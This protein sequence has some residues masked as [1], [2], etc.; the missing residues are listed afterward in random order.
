MCGKRGT[1]ILCAS[2]RDQLSKPKSRLDSEAWPIANADNETKQSSE[3]VP[4]AELDV[5]VTHDA[6]DEK[7]HNPDFPLREN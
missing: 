2:C 7:R 6:G 3:Q 1:S 4:F 5:E